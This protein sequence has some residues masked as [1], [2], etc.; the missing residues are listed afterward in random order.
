ML[1]A[2]FALKGEYIKSENKNYHVYCG[3]ASYFEAMSVAY[4]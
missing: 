2:Y 3:G 4:M 1:L